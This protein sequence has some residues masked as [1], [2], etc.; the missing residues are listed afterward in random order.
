M[1]YS[2]RLTFEG[3]GDLDDEAVM[4]LAGELE[5]PYSGAVSHR[6]STFTVQLAVSRGYGVDRLDAILRDVTDDV[7]SIAFGIGLHDVD[8]V[9][10]EIM[11]WDR[12]EAQLNEPTFPD[13]IGVS[14]LSELLKV[15]KARASELARFPGF[16][17]PIAI[18]KSGPVW[19]EAN[20][21]HYAETWV[22][23][24]GRPKK[25]Q[26]SQADIDAVDG[27]SK[28]ARNWHR[29]DMSDLAN[30]LGSPG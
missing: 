6:G 23:K 20:V 27:A 14:E 30:D 25:P 10:A 1:D 11:L 13:I 17:A 7:S 24:P 8:V 15:S 2:V 3:K 26:L 22:R 21:K 19:V 12:F 16:P 29:E 5:D 4:D 28:A 9:E 18:L